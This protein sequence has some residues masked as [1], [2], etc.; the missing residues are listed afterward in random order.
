MIE[1]KNLTFTYEDSNETVLKDFNLNINDGEFLCLIGHSGCGKSTLIHLL[2]GL[3]PMQQGKILKNNRVM[4]SPGS[5]RAVVFQQYSLFPWMTVR[6][7]VVF[8]AM[9][10]GRFSKAQADE[11]ADLFL[12]KT[13][14]LEHQ[15]K[16]PFQLSGGMRQR[17]AIAKALAMDSEVLLLDEPF[18]ALDH[19]IR[20]ELQQLLQQLWQEDKKTVVFVTHDLD[21]A[22][23]LGTRIV[24]VKDGKVDKELY[25]SERINEC[26][27][28]TLK[29][30]DCKAL[31]ASL[32]AWFK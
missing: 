14:L 13:E 7:N 18:G 31:R 22:L 2:A 24:F 11:R 23:I 16:Y 29:Y 27:A 19:Q 17:T 28:K 15:H 25:I 4:E 5:D 26:C 12:K 20:T 9:K 6:K 30:E 8:A 10:T 1:I 21:E 32:E 3:L